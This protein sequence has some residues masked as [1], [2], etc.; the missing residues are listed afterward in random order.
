MKNKVNSKILKYSIRKL[1]LGVGPIVIGTLLF[2]SYI[3]SQKVLAADVNFKYIEKTELNEDEKKLIKESIPQEY[4]NEDTYY[5][6]Y[7]K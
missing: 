6:I 4:K 7:Q 5:F 3:P 2:G 1:S